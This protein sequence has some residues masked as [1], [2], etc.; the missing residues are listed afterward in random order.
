MK[1][2][3]FAFLLTLI[4]M[5][6]VSA[7]DSTGMPNTHFGY[8]A[9][10]FPKIDCSN[11]CYNFFMGWGAG[12]ELARG[13]F[14]IIVQDSG[15]MHVQ[16]TSFAFLVDPNSRFFSNHRNKTLKDLLFDVDALFGFE[17]QLRTDTTFQIALHKYLNF[18]PIQNP[19][20]P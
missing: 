8:L 7:Q 14:N 13:S 1:Y 20:Q 11:G 3:S 15:L 2:L 10:D 6:S 9:G 4:L 12:R 16:D 18:L 5:G 17:P 19:Y